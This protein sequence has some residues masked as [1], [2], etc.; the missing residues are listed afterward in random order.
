M[1]CGELIALL[2][3]YPPD[4]R[5]QV[6]GEHGMGDVKEVAAYSFHKRRREID[7]RELIHMSNDLTGY[8]GV[9]DISNELAGQDGI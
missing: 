8:D 5:V 6:G 1:T 9:V 4:T 7:G 3:Q 2:Q